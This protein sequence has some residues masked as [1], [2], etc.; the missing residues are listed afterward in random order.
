[1][2]HGVPI[3]SKIEVFF[4]SCQLF[5]FLASAF[6]IFEYAFRIS[7]FRRNCRFGELTPGYFL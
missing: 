5:A 7:I 4:C 3:E 1:M 2:L 6:C